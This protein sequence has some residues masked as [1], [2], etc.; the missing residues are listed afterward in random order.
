MLCLE[1]CYFLR[2][3]YLVCSRELTWLSTVPVVFVFVG[4]YSSITVVLCVG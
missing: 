1:G 4:L 3:V 2:D